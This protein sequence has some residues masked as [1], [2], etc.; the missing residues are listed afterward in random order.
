MLTLLAVTLV[1]LMIGFV[2]QVIDRTHQRH[3]MLLLPGIA[4]LSGLLGWVIMQFTGLGYHPEL[5][6]LSWLLPLL[7]TGV[8]TVGTAW[9]LGRHRETED[10]AALR[11]VTGS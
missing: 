1:A 8:V 4:L 2:V 9:W 11:R 10:A 7:A 5:F 3:S 6:W